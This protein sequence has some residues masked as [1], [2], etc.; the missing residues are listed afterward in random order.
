METQGSLKQ[1]TSETNR[2]FYS[3]PVKLQ[4]SAL[5]SLSVCIHTSEAQSYIFPVPLLLT[6]CSTK[7]QHEHYQGACQMCTIWVLNPE[8]LHQN[9]HV[10]K[11]SRICILQSLRNAAC[12]TLF[13]GGSPKGR[14]EPCPSGQALPP[15]LGTLLLIIKNFVSHPIVP[16]EERQGAGWWAL[17]HFIDNNRQGLHNCAISG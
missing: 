15:R 17:A 13:K 10:N 5:T 9:L 16:F 4:L 2:P 11:I 1:S 6:M 12:E 3:V 8:I 7:Q 14:G